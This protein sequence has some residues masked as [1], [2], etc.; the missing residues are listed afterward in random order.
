MRAPKTAGHTLYGDSVSHPPT[1]Q[2]RVGARL[3]HDHHVPPLYLRP[4][5]PPHPE[6]QRTTPCRTIPASISPP[7]VHLPL[8]SRRAAP[9][10][11]PPPTPMGRRQRCQRIRV[12]GGDGGGAGGGGGRASG[13][14]LDGHDAATA[15]TVAVAAAAI[16]DAVRVEAAAVAVAVAI[17]VVTASGR[18]RQRPL[19]STY[20]G[21]YLQGGG[22]RERG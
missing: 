18:R 14:S 7:S 5:S 15:A 10:L 6:T 8:P 9:P 11:P 1:S 22:Q 19:C 4:T 17:A 13:G 3:S 21:R 12:G 16:V 2:C 20:G